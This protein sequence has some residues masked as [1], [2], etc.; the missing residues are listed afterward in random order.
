MT[1]NLFSLINIYNLYAITMPYKIKHI[2]VDCYEGEN[3]RHT[4]KIKTIATFP[5]RSQVENY[6]KQLTKQYR[7]MEKQ[8]GN[9]WDKVDILFLE[10]QETYDKNNL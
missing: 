5:G 8:K 7:E 2:R 10:I 4:M 9:I 1:S 6:R 3:I